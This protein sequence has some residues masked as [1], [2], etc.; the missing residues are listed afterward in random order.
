MQLSISLGAFCFY[1]WTAVGNSMAMNQTNANTRVKAAHNETADDTFIKIRRHSS[2]DVQPSVPSNAAKGLLPTQS[3]RVSGIV[4]ND[5]VPEHLA[6]STS[7]ADNQA[8]PGVA[9]ISLHKDTICENQ[10]KFTVPNQNGNENAI[11]HKILTKCSDTLDLGH[12][13]TYI[14]AD[15]KSSAVQQSGFAQNNIVPVYCEKANDCV[16]NCIAP[17]ARNNDAVNGAI[18]SNITADGASLGWEDYSATERHTT[19]KI[20]A[21]HEIMINGPVNEYDLTLSSDTS[22]HRKEEMSPVYGDDQ[23]IRLSL[24]LMRERNLDGRS[25]PSNGIDSEDGSYLNQKDSHDSATNGSMELF[26]SDG[27]N[28]SEGDNVELVDQIVPC[29]S[30]H[31]KFPFHCLPV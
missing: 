27:D 30:W 20:S 1:L 19:S 15:N 13:S 23:H 28:W 22:Q 29:T 24:L 16:V 12:F 26:H 11:D 10:A 6:S 7:L 4:G 14:D 17:V 21:N 3:D 9:I 31:N 18:M 5:T 8:V 2:G 25:S